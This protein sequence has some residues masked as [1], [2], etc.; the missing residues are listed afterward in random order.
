MRK[1][2]LILLIFTFF[3][4]TACRK[5]GENVG[6]QTEHQHNSNS[7]TVS[8][9]KNTYTLEFKS[10]PK[11]MVADSDTKLVFTI[12][13]LQGEVYK[14]LEIIHEKP[15]H[16]I[17][18]SEDLNEFYHLHPEPQSDGSL[19]VNFAFPTGGKYR[20]YVDFTPKDAQQSVR[21][22]PLQVSG[23]INSAKKLIPD[24]KFEKTVEGIKVLM[25]TGGNLESNKEMT[26]SFRVFDA[27]NGE[28]AEGM[29]KYLGETAHFVIISQD[30]KDFV[31][32]HP[33]SMDNIKDENQQN[34]NSAE[35]N[36]KLMN[37]PSNSQVSALAT[38]PNAG[39][40]K[41]FVEFQRYGK[42]IAVP[43]VVEVMKGKTDKLLENAKVPDG[44]FKIVL[45][46]D[47]FTPNEINL[48][49][50]K[51][52]KL[53]FLR[54]ESEVCNDGLVFMELKT[55]KKLPVGEIVTVEIPKDKTG[56]LNFTCGNDKFKGK[57]IIQ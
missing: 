43:F 23:G 38:F 52:Q 55:L 18:V 3:L 19:T 6:N 4:I 35:K 2:L 28:L 21:D 57:V 10:E 47:G 44:A 39:I 14:D 27:E 40:Y 29:E 26:L 7:E 49:K 50:D 9:D 5:D 56:E 37:I 48:S 25:E 45:S 46:K 32:V 13:N 42:V 1:H 53:V 24:A 34:S 11:E 20:L 8:T 41:I 30:L 51:F 15:M 12:K 16:L 31:H 54:V 17:I 36:Q 22:F 33:L